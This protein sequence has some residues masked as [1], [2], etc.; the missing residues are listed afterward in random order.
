MVSRLIRKCCHSY[1]WAALSALLS[2]WIAGPNEAMAILANQG[3]VLSDMW[4]DP[5]FLI[6]E[7]GA[8]YTFQETANKRLHSVAVVGYDR[9]QGCWIISN[10]LG[11]GWCEGG[12]GRVAFGSGGLL[13]ERGG[14][15]ILI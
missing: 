11:S 15:Q 12:F 8:I 4:I 6:L 10:S 14:Y 3:P 9:D 13:D 2:V 7:P 5:A 1:S